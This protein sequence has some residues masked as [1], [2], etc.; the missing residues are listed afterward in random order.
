MKISI[1]PSYKR[2]VSKNNPFL[3]NLYDC[4]PDE[5]QVHYVYGKNQLGLLKNLFRSKVYVIN[6]PENVIFDTLGLLQIIVFILFMHVL[7]IR[8]AKFVW[9]FHN[10]E[11]HEGH[12]FYSRYIYGFM[13]RHSSLVVSFSRKGAEYLKGKTKAI[14][15]YY[16]H[17]FKSEGRICEKT[18]KDWDI[19]IWGSIT[20]YK[21]IVEFLNYLKQ[22]KMLDKYRILITGRCKDIEYDRTIKTYQS[23]NIVYINEFLTNEDLIRYMDSSRYILFT[24][25]EDSVSSSGALMDTLEYGAQVIGPNVGAF[26]DV[27]DDGVGFTYINYCDIESI[28]DSGISINADYIK[29]YVRCNTWKQFGEK[30]YNDIKLLVK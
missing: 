9:I 8:R 15:K 24:Y 29:N 17:P 19:Y 16:P 22:N 27:K 7:L 12:N 10:I 3:N 4:F 28:I 6:W 23:E 20:K 1:Y 14:I 21:G 18:Q 11:P 13:M 26:K 30:L 25:L 2:D 5:A